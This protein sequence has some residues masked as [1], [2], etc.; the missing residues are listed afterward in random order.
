MGKNSKY[1]DH[2]I[3][4]NI[5]VNN[6]DFVR[7]SLINL[8]VD[9]YSIFKTLFLNEY[10]TSSLTVTKDFYIKYLKS[11]IDARL[12]IT[13]KLS[14]CGN[15]FD[16]VDVQSL[17]QIFPI[18]LERSTHVFIITD[19][20]EFGR[21]NKRIE[22]STISEFLHSPNGYAVFPTYKF[23]EQFA[24]HIV[25]TLLEIKKRITKFSK[26]QGI[27]PFSILDFGTGAASY[28]I[29][30][31]T[32]LHEE[33]PELQFQLVGTEINPRA[34][35]FAEQN[36]LLNDLS[37]KISTQ[38]I[39][40]LEKNNINQYDVIIANPPYVPIPDEIEKEYESWGKAGFDGLWYTLKLIEKA[41][42]LLKD[43]GIMIL[44]IYSLG[45]ELYPN[46]LFK[47]IA[48]DSPLKIIASHIF[49]PVWVGFNPT[50]ISNPIHFDYLSLRFKRGEIP[51][52]EFQL[53]RE[54]N[55][56]ITRLSA[57]HRKDGNSYIHHLLVV[58]ERNA[59][60]DH[61][62]YFARRIKASDLDEIIAIEQQNEIWPLRLQASLEKIA[63]RFQVYPEGFWSIFR[64]DN[65]KW[66]LCGFSTAQP[67][68]YA[69]SKIGKSWEQLTM[70]GKINITAKSEGNTLQLVSAA[71]LP[72]ER[73]QGLWKHMVFLRLMQTFF[74]DRSMALVD[75]RIP[76]QFGKEP[77]NHPYVMWLEDI[78]F[79]L[80]DVVGTSI[81]DP[82]S[83]NKAVLL[84]WRR[85]K[86]RF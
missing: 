15:D 21:K 72:T 73:R 34:I 75:V 50:W 36:R 56:A 67:L 86:W 2:G 62:K 83:Q 6:R 42:Q 65:A 79:Q 9:H 84:K 40:G 25:W 64:F 61:R 51:D 82:E 48:D 35:K 11:L 58:V 13:Q 78:G 81:D 66:N 24:Y 49:P 77:Q 54:H 26:K 85:P 43:D 19:W 37:F 12:I 27:E 60:N 5:N 68:I 30:L 41:P 29:M 47:K 71:V 52:E 31:E 63:M 39:I 70:F 18:T 16:F 46:D 76:Q 22:N 14:T 59:D 8:L 3:I 45:D 32:L 53:N 28:L 74:E 7:R 69:S 33:Y 17:F 57:K 44:V 80:V 55:S 10:W 1:G 38:N 4:S 23:R 20:D